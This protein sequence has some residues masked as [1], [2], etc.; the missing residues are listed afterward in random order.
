ML[1]TESK[2]LPDTTLYQGLHIQLANLQFIIKQL[3]LRIS[4]WE[5]ETEAQRGHNMKSTR[6]EPSLSKSYLVSIKLLKKPNRLGTHFDL[7]QQI[8]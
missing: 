7:K 5:G 2:I 6:P 4:F 3:V 8:I 1:C